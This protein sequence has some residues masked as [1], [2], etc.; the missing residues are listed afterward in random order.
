MNP[1]VRGSVILLT[2]LLAIFPCGA[3]LTVLGSA[4]REAMRIYQSD[5]QFSARL[6]PLWI[7][8]LWAGGG[9]LGFLSLIHGID[10]LILA[11]KRLTWPA[12][13]GIL[14]ALGAAGFFA[15]TYPLRGSSALLFRLICVAP[16]AIALLLLVQHALRFARLNRAGDG[17][18]GNSSGVSHTQF[19]TFRHDQ[20]ADLKR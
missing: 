10:R 18:G 8:V 13:F 14:I 17:E 2:C 7:P 5:G 15:V 9:A 19:Q 20:S 11:T 1:A 6:I 12:I 16:V 3:A 4:F